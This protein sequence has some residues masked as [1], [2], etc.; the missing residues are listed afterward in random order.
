MMFDQHD[1]GTSR[2]DDEQ[3]WQFL[4]FSQ[5]VD[6]L[7]RKTLFFAR[8]DTLEDPF[9][10]SGDDSARALRTLP[11]EVM[12]LAEQSSAPP[13]KMGKLERWW[14]RKTQESER[15][16]LVNTIR[17]YQPP[18]LIWACCWHAA[19]PEQMMP[20]WKTYRALGKQVAVCTTVGKLRAALSAAPEA[21]ISVDT[22][23]YVDPE[24]LTRMTDP[25]EKALAKSKTL[26]FE[27]EVRAILTRRADNA[28]GCFGRG[29]GVAVDVG[30]LMTGVAVSPAAEVWLRD[31]VSRVMR[32]YG[33][34]AIAADAEGRLALPDYTPERALPPS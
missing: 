24:S 31:L 32:S 25:V 2:G 13:R 15:D 18:S 12:R 11:D 30:G 9:A 20:L 6:M 21:S 26:A 14:A 17:N 28:N 29:C 34:N 1:G 5:F 8:L 7:D 23:R 19:D 22:V 10:G 27:R 3:I 33:I 16:N 4:E